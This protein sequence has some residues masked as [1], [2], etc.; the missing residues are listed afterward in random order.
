MKAFESG[1]LIDFLKP[2]SKP[3]ILGVN[4]FYYL[5]TGTQI[6]ANQKLIDSENML[7]GVQ[8]KRPSLPISDHFLIEQ[9]IL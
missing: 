9:G 6:S 4:Q 7:K 8:K 3:R 2:I 5:S 1:G